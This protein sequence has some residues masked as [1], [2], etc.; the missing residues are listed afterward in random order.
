MHL[1]VFCV[2]ALRAI[3]VVCS[4]LGKPWYIYTQ[5]VCIYIVSFLDCFIYVLKIPLRPTNQRPA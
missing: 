4:P 1:T 3:L 2:H 5:L